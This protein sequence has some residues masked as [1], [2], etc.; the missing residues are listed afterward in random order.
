MTTIELEEKVTEYIS[1]MFDKLVKPEMEKWLK[2]HGFVRWE[3]SMG[4]YVFFREDEDFDM[5]D[6]DF[7]DS[8]DKEYQDFYKKYLE[9]IVFQK[10]AKYQS[11]L[12]G[13]CEL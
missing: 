6:D 7:R 8:K 12:F 1:E 11:I 9:L 4:G 10:K 2:E 13:N 5:T 3:S